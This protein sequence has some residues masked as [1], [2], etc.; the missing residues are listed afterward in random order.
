[1]A[2]RRIFLAAA[3]TSLVLA[4]RAAGILAAEMELADGI[5]SGAAAAARLE[6]LPG[7]VPLIKLTYR[8]PNYE[9]PFALLRHA[10]HAERRLLRPLPPRRYPRGRRRRRWKLR[11]GGEAAD[12]RFELTL[13][14]LKRGFE[15]VELAAV[16]QCSG[17]RRGVRSRTCRA[18]SGAT[19][20]M[21]NAAGKEPGSRTCSPGP[22][23]E[24]GASR[25]PSTAPMGRSLEETPDFV[26]S[27]PALEGA[28]REHPPRLRDERRAPAPLERLSGAPRRAGLDRHLLDEAPDLASRCRPSP[29]PAS[30]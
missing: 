14:E 20:A 24:G 4:Q 25:S 17:N 2:S 19:G 6:A 7:K 21:G 9:T 23:S 18:S 11:V 1:M 5:P 28:R 12:R 30:G 15:P 22:A 16:C 13:D 8:P 27:M 3:G 10:D 29:S 26:K